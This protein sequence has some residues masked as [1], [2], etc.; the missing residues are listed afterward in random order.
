MIDGLMAKYP[1][2][3]P[4]IVLTRPSIVVDRHNRVMLWYLPGII[5]PERQ[6]SSQWSV[7]I[8]IYHRAH[9]NHKEDA[10]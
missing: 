3:D 5:T 10:R 2:F 9:E 7:A 1:P 4:T 8:S 6:V